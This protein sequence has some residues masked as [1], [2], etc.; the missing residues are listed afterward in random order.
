VNTMN[1]LLSYKHHVYDTIL[2]GIGG[3]L[4][5]TGILGFLIPSGFFDGG[6][7]GLSML[8]SSLTPI[9]LSWF[10]FIVNIPFLVIG[11]NRFGHVFIARCLLT[12]VYFAILVAVLN[13]PA[14]SQDK[15][16]CSVFGGILLGS[17]IGFAVN[18]GSVLDGTEI[19]AIMICQKLGISIGT[20]ILG[21]NVIIFAV[22]ASVKGY[23]VALYSILAYIFASKSANFLIHGIEEYIGISIVSSHSGKIRS[24]LVEEL[25][26]GVTVYHGRTGLEKKDQEILFCVVTKYDMQRLKN[27][28]KAIDEKAFIVTQPVDN[29]TGG[30]VKTRVRKRRF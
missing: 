27:I 25:N 4:A 29:V 1:K 24:K 8:G 28:I 11:W 16:L 20:I 23:E 3:L 21:F 30:L 7:T 13:V 19:A 10:L 26:L 17:G 5:A 9:H 6:V 12:I 14:L 18:G 22:I 15:I 2:I